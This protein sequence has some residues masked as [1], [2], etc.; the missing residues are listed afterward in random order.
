[1]QELIAF[2]LKIVGGLGYGGIFILMFLES[3]FF[4]F[5]SEV[6]MIPV[7]YL[8]YR[9]DM[10]LYLV[11]LLGIGGSY[12]GALFNYFLARKYGRNFL[13][14]Y[15]KYF[16]VNPK[17]LKKLEY[18]FEKHG[19]ISTFNGRLIP[20]VR[21]YISLPAGLA[22]MNLTMFS[23][24]TILGAGIWIIILTLLGFFIGAHKQLIKEN[25]HS[26]TLITLMSIAVITL[27]YCWLYKKRSVQAGERTNNG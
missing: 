5:P 9:G 15:G 12:L 23:L 17:M 1:M 3:S 4:P 26:V 14:K 8:A 10:N 22:K 6:V 7:G 21:Q 18:F 27:G 19:A 11:I 2:I 16:F 13:V 24:Y 20:G 25:L